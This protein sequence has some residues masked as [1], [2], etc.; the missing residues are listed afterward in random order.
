ARTCRAGGTAH[1]GTARPPRPL[2]PAGPARR[3]RF[4]W[5]ARP[6]RRLPMKAAGVPRASW[7]SKTVLKTVLWVRLE[8]SMT[9]LG[10][11]EDVGDSEPMRPEPRRRPTARQRALLADLEALFLAEGFAAFTL[12]DLAGRL[13][14]SKSTLYALAPSKEQLAVK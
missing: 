11:P 1:A 13:R 7:S 10:W 2:P 6:V 5:S 9:G 3:G 8:Y 4:P 14:C 12:D